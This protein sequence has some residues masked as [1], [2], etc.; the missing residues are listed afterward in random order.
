MTRLAAQLVA[1]MGQDGS[2]RTTSDP[3]EAP[4]ARQH[5]R[6]RLVSNEL[7]EHS[8]RLFAEQGF[9]NTS[10]QDIADAMGISRPALY[11]Y[12]S[13]KE[14]LL[15]ALVH[16]VLERVVEILERTRARTDVTEDVR[17]EL[18]L[19]EIIVNNARNTTRFRLLDRSEPDLP[20]E[21]AEMHR[22]ARR[23]VLKLFAGMI[24]DAAVAGKLRPLPA[25]TVAL[26]MLGVA[27]WVAWWYRPGIDGDAE[28]IADVL[29]DMVMTGV[30][31]GADRTVEAGP[32]AA[33]ALLKEDI[34]HLESAMSTLTPITPDDAD[35]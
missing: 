12:V 22:Q 7:L 31:R 30:R 4:M 23:R 10:F 24:E 35:S 33:L 26:G 27:N 20:A 9:A 19:R 32:W 5:T 34:V 1:A 3:G 17:V 14:E 29:V 8:A 2:A 18:A 25:R 15:A 28:Q 11:H 21:I 6:R 13:N 16:D